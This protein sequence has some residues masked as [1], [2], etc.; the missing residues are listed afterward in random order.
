MGLTVGGGP[1]VSTLKMHPGPSK[2][3]RLLKQALPKAKER[4]QHGAFMQ[5]RRCLVLRVL[6]NDPRAEDNES[7]EKISLF[8][9]SFS[10][11]V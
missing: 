7:K 9:F 11:F 8:S 2:A 6:G 3:N 10:L 1:R 5:T 4:F